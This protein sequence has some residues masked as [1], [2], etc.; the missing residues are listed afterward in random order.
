MA[1]KVTKAK[2]KKPSLSRWSTSSPF[3]AISQRKPSIQRSK[4]KAEL[5][6]DDADFED[7]LDDLGL[8]ETLATDL[9]LRD[10]PQAME[11]ILSHMFDPI[12]V[13]KSGMNSAQ[14]AE[15]L[16]YRKNL[17]PIVTNSHIHALIKSPTMVE[18]EIAELAAAGIVRRITIPGRGVGA[19][20]ISDALVLV[21]DWITK[22]EEMEDILSS[23]RGQDRCRKRFLYLNANI[24]QDKYITLLK[25]KVPGSLAPNNLFTD[26]EGISLI[27][28]GFLTSAAASKDH[29]NPSASQSYNTAGTLT[30]VTSIAK[31]A[32]GSLAATGGHGAI[33]R[34]GGG[35]SA[36]LNALR[37]GQPQSSLPNSSKTSKS[38]TNLKISIPGTG[39]FLKLIEGARAHFL[40][41][42]SR[43]KY[44]EAPVYLMRERWSG[45]VSTK[46]TYGRSRDAF[47]LIL[48]GKTKKWK[49][50]YGL[51]FDFILAECLGSGLIE[52]FNTGSVGLGVRVVS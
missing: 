20:S 31:A 5:E 49:E 44:N 17:S 27:R 36:G 39:T 2:A 41:L 24:I 46:S 13:E 22:M 43:S 18:R 4:S 37:L 19:S 8:V 30:S 48:P 7:R 1:Y 42:L 26:E 21:K 35:G 34:V 32:S 33:H 15:K 28:A 23:I 12:P 6:P 9:S 50:F 3:S 51:S 47:S 16:N 11:Y 52:V 29:V 38:E 40:H 10:V 25:S 14:T 45:G